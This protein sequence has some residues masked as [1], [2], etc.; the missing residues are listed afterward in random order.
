MNL[1]SIKV[2]DLASGYLTGMEF[3]LNRNNTK[4]AASIVVYGDIGSGI[5]SSG[6]N[7]HP[8]IQVPNQ[9]SIS[10][11]TTGYQSNRVV[12]FSYTMRIDR[13]PIYK[14]G[15]PFPVQVERKFPITQKLISL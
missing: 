15:S 14:I 1:E 10:V 13:E 6:N 8:D 12:D 7:A 5:D 11:N 3:S 9:G 4:A 2:L